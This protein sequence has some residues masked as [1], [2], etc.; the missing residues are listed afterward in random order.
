MMAKMPPPTPHLPY[1]DGLNYPYFRKVINDTIAH[2]P[3]WLVMP[4]KVPSN[5]PKFKSHVREDPSN[6]IMPFYLCHSS[7]NIIEYSVQLCL[8]QW[9]LMG[10]STKWYV[11]EPI[12]TYDIIEGIAKV[13]F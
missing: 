10:P 7:N 4:T 8:F 5:I 11:N 1:M 13:F 3:T 6:Q 12:G 2:D 9:A